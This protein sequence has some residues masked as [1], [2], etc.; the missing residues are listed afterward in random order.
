MPGFRSLLWRL[1]AK[2]R[3]AGFKSLFW[4]SGGIGAS[5][6]AVGD[7]A[8]VF[9]A[10]AYSAVRLASTGRRLTQAWNIS[11]SNTSDLERRNRQY[12]D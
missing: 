9:T 12:D 4:W 3:P 2:P 6:D 8:V 11:R 10:Q 5:V 1:G 7:A